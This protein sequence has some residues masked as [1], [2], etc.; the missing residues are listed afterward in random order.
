MAFSP[1]TAE[2]LCTQP[3]GSVAVRT[4][5]KHAEQRLDPVALGLQGPAG[6]SGYEL[7]SKQF[8]STASPSN[9]IVQFGAFVACP[10]GKKVLGGGGSGA[11][12]DTASAVHP[13]AVVSSMPQFIN[14]EYEWV[15]AIQKSTGEFFLENERVLGTVFA[16]CASVQ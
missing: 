15:I 1:V 8:E 12:V 10:A 6:V 14:G 9:T 7:V 2:V 13:A 4:A 5:C 3:S 16:I 11:W